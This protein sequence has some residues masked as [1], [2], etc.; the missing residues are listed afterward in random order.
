MSTD[1]SAVAPIAVLRKN[2]VEEIRVGL[3]Q[4]GGYDLA[5]VRVWFRSGDEWRPGKQGIAV[6]LAMLPKLIAALND[7]L[8]EAERRGIVPSGEKA[9]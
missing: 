3:D 2:T 8:A 5:N 6:R 9:A 4:Y 7:T 1:R